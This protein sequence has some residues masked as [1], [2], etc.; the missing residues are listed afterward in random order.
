MNAT[1]SLIEPLAMPGV[2]FSCFCA[3]TEIG[4]GGP[5]VSSAKCFN[6]FCEFPCPVQ[7]EES[8]VGLIAIIVMSR[9]QR[10]QNHE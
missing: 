3:G 9:F 2:Y 5:L 8:D 4:E 6:E 1:D 10:L 7:D